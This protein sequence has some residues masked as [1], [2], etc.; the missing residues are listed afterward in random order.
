VLV[1]IGV[2]GRT[3]VTRGVVLVELHLLVTPVG[4]DMLSVMK[5]SVS[6]DPQFP[7]S[8]DNIDTLGVPITLLKALL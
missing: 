4:A 3:G 5:L 2:I 1:T 8:A 7:T 6:F